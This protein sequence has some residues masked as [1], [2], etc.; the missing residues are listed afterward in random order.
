MR[1]WTAFIIIVSL[2]LST[3]V[4]PAWLVIDPPEFK[5]W[6][7]DSSIPDLQAFTVNAAGTSIRQF[8]VL[9]ENVGNYEV[10]VVLDT[11]GYPTTPPDR[12]LAIPD[13]VAIGPTYYFRAFL[14]DYASKKR[15]AG[16][17]DFCRP[18]NMTGVPDT[19]SNLR[20]LGL[21][22]SLIHK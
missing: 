18:N 16:V 9:P 1:S 17:T 7:Y 13:T 3:Q 15:S 21:A 14:V 5:A 19:P 12:P 8:Q 2:Y 6:E 22:L 20:T 4:A 10:L 11:S